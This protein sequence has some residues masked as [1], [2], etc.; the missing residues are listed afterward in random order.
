MVR[1]EFFS[2][3]VATLLLASWIAVPP[4]QAKAKA[5]K[6]SNAGVKPLHKV[7][8]NDVY[9]PMDINNIFNYYSN[10]GDGSFNPFT[11]S[12]EGFEFPIGSTDGTC[13]FEDGLVW[14]AF[15]NDTLYCGGST[16]NHGLQAGRI[17]SNGTASSLGVA[18]SASDPANKPYRVRPDIRPTTNADTIALETN[19]LQNSE[20]TYINQFQSTSASDLLQQYWNDWTNWPAAE[21]APY[22][23]VNHNGV[24]D[25][26]VDVPGFPGADQTIW[27]VMNDLNPTRTLNLY[28]S[29]P[30]GVEVQRTIWAYNR[31]GALGNTIFISYKFINKSGVELD[32]MYVSQ[33][34]DPDLGFAGD[35]AT[36]C[37]TTRSLGFVYNGEARDANFANIGLPPPS[38]GF[39]FFQGPKVAGAATDTAI[40]G[41]KLVPGYKNLPMTA[42]TFFINGNQ[43]F[44]DPQLGSN[45]PGGTQQW[46]N[47]MRCRV[48]TTGLP[49]DASVTGGSNYCYPGDPVTNSGPTFI[50]SGSV[51]APADVRMCLNSGPFTMAPGDTQEVVVAALVGL[52]ADNLS[53]ISVLRSNDD[54][55]QSAY[56]AFFQLAVPPPAPVVHV[57]A[58]DKE[59]VLSWGDPVASINTESAVSKGYTF[60]GYNVYQYPRNNTS[61]GK[62]IATYDLIDGIKTIQD[63]VFS[64]PLGTYVVTPTEYGTDNGIA[65]SIDLTTDAL[66]GTPIANNRDYY[67][68]V[69]AYN[70]NPTGGLVPHALESSPSILDVR[71]Q[72]PLNGVRLFNKPGDTLAIT[73]TGASDGYVIARVVDPTV[74]TGDTYNVGFAV[75]NVSG[76]TYWNLT[77]ATKG[78]TIATKQ[79]Q[80]S[81]V[82]PPPG[83]NPGPITTNGVALQVYGPPPGM[84][85]GGQGVGWNI[86]SGKRDWSSL[87][88][89]DYGLEGFNVSGTGGAMGMGQDWGNT[90]G[91][92]Q[93]TVTPDKL[94][95][96]LIKFATID[97]AFNITDPTDPNV[98]QAYRFLRHSTSAF[99][100]PDSAT[101]DPHPGAG[102]AYQGRSA[103]PLAAFDE[104]NNNQRLDVGFLENNAGGGTP[105]GKY[106]PPS[107]SSGIETTTPREYLFIFSTPY[108]ATVDNPLIPADILDDAS[109]MMWWIVAVMRGSNLFAA[110]DE[111]EI[112]PNYVNSAAV[113]FSFK[114]VAP[115]DNPADQKADIAKIN[116]FPNPYFG[117]NR[118][119]ADKYNR[120]VRFTHMP[121]KAT[122]R[123]FNLAGI[124]VR[125][126]VKNDLT[127]FSDWDLLNEHKLPVAAGMYIAY[128][129]CG[130]LGTKTLK[131]AIIP[132]QQFLD[133]Y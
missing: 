31:P 98:S 102:Y 113:T 63:T 122:I 84:N 78:T 65:H 111:F 85:P 7:Q 53:S 126:I 46:Y 96:V 34:C 41:G 45:G 105:D 56:N 101:V 6:S 66:T 92:G 54:I 115:T 15:K 131:F 38:A 48:S 36:G 28:S 117:F 76:N 118:L 16:Y 18:A 40:F 10:N 80:S 72:S 110:G 107:T 4:A 26:G 21:G 79:V 73:K 89:G 43:Q 91:A 94:H 109:P 74:L 104:D 13:I 51:S 20:V 95:K 19:L 35:D 97:T 106:D 75:D 27:M 33:W 30:I 50:G 23:D 71:P 86:P 127:Q 116:V 100:F 58:L 55:A 32:S 77:D 37:D 17:V 49:F 8:T 125:T 64:V 24:Y 93:S 59:I 103:V 70:Y 11:T 14:T 5:D 69:T 120:W 133:H 22:T 57:A 25:P 88:A 83:G 67:F 90:F 47:L 114:S 128:I 129:D 87:D 130:S 112:I 121:S 132:E 9:A 81:A 62:L 123:I 60:E 68:A 1:K 99:P 2:A 61:G 108:S 29:N 82:T 12:D 3:I 119:E 39:D 42:F 124:L 52:G 44:T